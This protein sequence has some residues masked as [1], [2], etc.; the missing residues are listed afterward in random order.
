MVVRRVHSLAGASGQ[1]GAGNDH[2]HM[3]SFVSAPADPRRHT[4]PRA[5]PCARSGRKCDVRTRWRLA[6]ST[7]GTLRVASG[8]HRWL[9]IRLHGYDEKRRSREVG[10]ENELEANA[11]VNE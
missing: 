6:R 4:F 1:L 10:T 11:S 3:D 7:D 5:P 2:A 8:Q 9:M